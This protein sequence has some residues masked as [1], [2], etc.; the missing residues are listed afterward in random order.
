MQR[1]SC[2]MFYIK[3]HCVT[4]PQSQMSLCFFQT[5]LFNII[6]ICCCCIQ[7][8]EAGI[9]SADSESCG[10]TFTPAVIAMPHIPTRPTTTDVARSPTLVK[11]SAAG[12]QMRLS[13]NL[14]LQKPTPEVKA[15]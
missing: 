5:S 9:H 15:G 13:T 7:I 1:R 6:S 8:P 12:V 11:T 10:E 4:W 2:G 3:F 14:T